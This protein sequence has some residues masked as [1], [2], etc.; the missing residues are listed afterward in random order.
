LTITEFLHHLDTHNID[1]W[2]QDSEIFIRMDTNIPLPDMNKEKKALKMRLLN[3]QFAK[4]RGW[5]V[6]NFGEIYCY[7]YSDSGHI[8]I[9]RNP[10]ESVNIYR[11][12]FDLY[13]KPTN[14][15]GYH[16]G[17]SFSEA[18]QKAKAFLDWFY[19]KNPKLKR[20]TY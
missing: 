7:Q 19:A 3:N 6:G 9:E 12:K 1:I 11:C 10:D 16:E 13:G 4:Q 8:F 18:Y 2:V 15:K 17:I 14:I 5:L 20:G